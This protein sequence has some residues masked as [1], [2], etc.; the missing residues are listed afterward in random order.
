MVISKTP[1]TDG[2]CEKYD[3]CPKCGSE[4]L[5]FRCECESEEGRKVFHI[6]A[7]CSSI[8]CDW[9]TYVP[10]LKNADKNRRMEKDLAKW[11]EAVLNR[12]GHKCQI[13]GCN[14]TENLHAHHKLPK[15]QYPELAL[16]V[17]NG[18][19]L[20]RKHHEA[21]HPWM[22]NKIWNKNQGLK[23]YAHERG[24]FMWEIAQRMDM[25]ESALCR[26]LQ[27]DLSEDEER[28]IRWIIDCI[29]REHRDRR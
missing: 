9:K 18:I 15:A 13:P 19:T 21:M 6:Q 11:R 29:E 5:Y 2:Y 8:F 3:K 22:R 17:A 26:K 7:E 10:S 23:Y 1:I 12:D 14:E 25:H 28:N 27:E 24:V 4:V 20:C 16:V